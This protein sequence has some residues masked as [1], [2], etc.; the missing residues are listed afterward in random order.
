MRARPGNLTVTSFM[1]VVALMVI[2]AGVATVL[3]EQMRQSLEVKQVSIAKIQ[4][5]YL[6]EMGLNDIMNA[7]NQ[8]PAAPPWPANGAVVDFTSKV[9]MVRGTTGSASCT[10]LLLSAN[11]RRYQV[12]ATLRVAGDPAVYQRGLEFSTTYNGSLWTLAGY[13]LIK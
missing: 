3:Q 5:A 1:I 7:A 10:Y 2:F 6:A 12:Q 9:A 13:T 4:A 11:P 8:S